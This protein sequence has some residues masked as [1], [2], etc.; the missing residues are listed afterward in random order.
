[1][2]EICCFTSLLWTLERDIQQVPADTMWLRCV[3]LLSHRPLL[4]PRSSP[5]SP[6]TLSLC[7][8][9]WFVCVCS[10]FGPSYGVN[11]VIGPSHD[12]EDGQDVSDDLGGAPV[13][14]PK[15]RKKT[16]TVRTHD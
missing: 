16:N 14:T 8:K 15:K 6:P 5:P 3:S 13:V 11:T 7:L 1:M 10:V 9:K 12:V 4:P 2:M